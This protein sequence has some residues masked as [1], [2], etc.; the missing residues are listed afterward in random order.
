MGEASPTALAMEEP[1]D[2]FEYNDPLSLSQQNVVN[3]WLQQQQ[4]QP[5]YYYYHFIKFYFRAE[6]RGCRGGSL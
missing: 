6:L 5:Y 2:T 1:P 3:A 4:Q